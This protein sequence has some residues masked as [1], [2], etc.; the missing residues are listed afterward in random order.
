M[1]ESSAN[2]LKLAHALTKLSSKLGMVSVRLP[3]PLAA[4]EAAGL[5]RLRHPEGWTVTADCGILK[6]GLSL[7]CRVDPD[8]TQSVQP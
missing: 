7:L 8:P 5:R 2:S 4:P 1:G 6:A 3:H